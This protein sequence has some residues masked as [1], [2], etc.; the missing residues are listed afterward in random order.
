MTWTLDVTLIKTLAI[1]SLP[2]DVNHSNTKN[3]KENIS[4]DKP[5]SSYPTTIITHASPPSKTVTSH[6]PPPHITSS[7]D[8]PVT[9]CSNHPVSNTYMSENQH[10]LG[11]FTTPNTIQPLPPLLENSSPTSHHHAKV[12]FVKINVL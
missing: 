11:N 5:V 9:S 2:I 10:N 6:T 8:A 1:N 7:H 3:L 4:N 12:P